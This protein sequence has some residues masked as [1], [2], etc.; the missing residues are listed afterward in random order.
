LNVFLNR[1]Y[2]ASALK[3]VRQQTSLDIIEG[4]E[5]SL[6]FLPKMQ[7]TKYIIRLHGGHHF[8]SVELGKKPRLGRGCF[9]RISFWNADY[10]CAVS[11]YVANRTKTLLKFSSPV[12]VI[13]NPVDTE[14]F[15]PSA[16]E[17]DPNLIAFVGTVCEKKGV[18]QLIQ[19]MPLVLEKH[20]DARLW[21]IG[22]DQFDKVRNTSFT[23]LLKRSVDPYVLSRVEILGA[24][25]HQKIP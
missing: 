22:R 2:L 25:S 19:A 8:F 6:A 15:S 3:E 20:P 1:L 17:E 4:A 12:E 7:G 16:Y 18:L 10:F 5:L 24:I 23:A 9:E 11:Q 14:M 13:P 21:V